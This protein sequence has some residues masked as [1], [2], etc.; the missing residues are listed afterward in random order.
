MLGIGDVRLGVVKFVNR[1]N[2]TLD[3][4]RPWGRCGVSICDA[5]SS[6]RLS[7]TANVGEC[8]K[9]AHGEDSAII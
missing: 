6:G 8:R 2:M 1:R 7:N 5:N 9:L 3:I 4:S